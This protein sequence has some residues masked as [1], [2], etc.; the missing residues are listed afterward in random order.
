MMGDVAARA[1]HRIILV[2]PAHHA[3][4][5]LTQPQWQRV[6]LRRVVRRQDVDEIVKGALLDG[7]RA[8]HIGLRHE[9]PGLQEELPVKPGIVQP[10]RCR[11]AGRPLEHM[12]LA[13]RVDDAEPT[14]A[15]E[16]GEHGSEQH[17]QILSGKLV[18]GNKTLKAEWRPT[19]RSQRG[20]RADGALTEAGHGR[21]MDS[22]A[23]PWRDR[24]MRKGTVAVFLSAGLSWLKRRRRSHGAETVAHSTSQE[25]PRSFGSPRRV[26]EVCR[27]RSRS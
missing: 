18:K 12:P 9:D 10:D 8:R 17:T 27:T 1:R 2:Q 7:Q 11:G 21:V 6:D 15:D 24:P 20:G 13:G 25:K 26:C 19:D 22:A 14:D 3:P 16:T 5:G 4:S 23:M